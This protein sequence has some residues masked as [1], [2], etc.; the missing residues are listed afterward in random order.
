MRGVPG[1]AGL[2]TFTAMRTWCECVGPAVVLVGVHWDTAGT[3]P[4]HT[5]DT[6]D[7][8]VWKWERSYIPLPCTL[9]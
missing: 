1:P 6:A 7:R 9:P 4:S 2:A 8:K 3:A 5:A